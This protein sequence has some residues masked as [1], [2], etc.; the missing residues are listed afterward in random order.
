VMLAP[1]TRL[2]TLV[3][4][5]C[6]LYS[7]LRTQSAGAHPLLNRYYE[8][9]V[10]VGLSADA[11]GRVVVEVRYQL[12]VN[13]LIALRDAQILLEQRKEEQPGNA[14]EYFQAF[15]RLHAPLLA[16]R[17][18]VAID[19]KGVD[20]TCDKPTYR[21]NAKDGT[22]HCDFVFRATAKPTAG[23]RHTLTVEEGAYKEEAGRVLLTL[24]AD[25]SLNV[26][27]RDEP[28]AEL[29]A[30][31]PAELKIG[32][33]ERMR[34]GSITFTL[35]A[36]SVRNAAPESFTRDSALEQPARAGAKNDETGSS[37]LDLLFDSSRGFALLLVLA[38]LFGAFHALTPGHGKTLVAAYL[39]GERGTIGHAILLGLVTT[40]T[41]T[42]AVLILAGVL[43]F[44]PQTN[45]AQVQVFLGLGGGFLVASMGFFLLYR[46]LAGQVDHFHFGSGHHHHH[47]PGHGHHRHAHGSAD[48]Y[49]D[50]YGHA[51]PLPGAGAPVGVWSL[52]VLGVS[53]GIVPCT[54]AIV[55]LLVAVGKGYLHRALPLLLAFSAGLAGVLVAIGMLVVTS[56]RFAG[57]H[58]GES[59]LI[60]AL[61]IVSAF[62]VTGLGLWLCYDAVHGGTAAFAG[63]P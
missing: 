4:V 27:G 22:L 40:F 58:F 10:D 17:V 29:K 14:K 12:E 39:V 31:S 60:R 33:D 7:V 48:H 45:A 28:S 55:M 13:Q 38:A 52:I 2:I 51:Q 41:H 25:S 35:D 46:R 32:D 34:H 3:A 26:L 49:H 20:L 42:G 16:D 36:P 9:T 1:R 15:A 5:L 56:K 54:D 61:P 23:E 30:R 44:F 37:L 47:D 62:L 57:S 11:A 43:W 21:L 50:E 19:D 63:K 53:G 6:T 59:R 18:Y 24:G 8:R